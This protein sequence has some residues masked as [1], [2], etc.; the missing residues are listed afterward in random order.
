MQL[1]ECLSNRALGKRINV[2]FLFAK[3]KTNLFLTEE[4]IETTFTIQYNTYEKVTVGIDHKY[5]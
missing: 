4:R 2:I 5:G 3:T 1:K